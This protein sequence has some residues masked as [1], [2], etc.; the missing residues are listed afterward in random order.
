MQDTHFCGKMKGADVFFI[1]KT[2]YCL[3][4]AALVQEKRSLARPYSDKVWSLFRKNARKGTTF[5]TKFMQHASLSRF[6]SPNKANCVTDWRGERQRER[7]ARK[8]P[9]V[10]GDSRSPG[11]PDRLPLADGDAMKSIFQFIRLFQEAVLFQEQLRALH[12]D[13]GCFFAQAATRNDNWQVM[14]FCSVAFKGKRKIRRIGIEG[15]VQRSFV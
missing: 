7:G 15:T 4:F 5:C 1:A 11:K 10:G 3:S 2:E 12:L 6:F 9:V 13:S 14:C 8:G